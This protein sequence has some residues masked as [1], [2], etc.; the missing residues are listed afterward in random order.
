MKLFDNPF[1]I[2]GAS[3]R[4]DRRRIMELYDERSFNLDSDI[5]SSAKQILT[6][7]RKRLAAEVAWLPGLRPNYAS[8]VLSILRNTPYEVLEMN[9]IPSLAYANIL[10][11]C[12]AELSDEVC[13][14]QIEMVKNL[15]ITFE[16]IDHLELSKFIN[17]DRQVAGFPDVLDQRS[18]ELELRERQKYYRDTV[19][20]WL[21]KI[22]TRQLVR[23]VTEIV[24]SMTDSG[25]KH[26]PL[27]I[28][29]IVDIY[30]VEAQEFFNKEE[31]NITNLVGK[32]RQSVVDDKPE[33]ENLRLLKQLI[34]VVRNWDT[35]AQPIQVSTRSRGVKH[36]NSHGVAVKLRSLAIFLFNEHGKIDYA[37]Q[38][39]ALLKEAFAEVDEVAEIS[40]EDSALLDRIANESRNEVSD[41][42]RT[43]AWQSEITYEAKIGFILKNKFR[44]SLDGIEWLGN[45][46]SLESVTRVRWGGTKSSV[47]GIPTGTQYSIAFGGDRYLQIINL[48]KS[49]IYENIIDRIWKAVGE[50]LIYDL[51]NSLKS[52]NEH[53]FGNAIICDD[54][55][56]LMWKRYFRKTQ[57]V[58][59][60]WNDTYFYSD[61]G[62]LIILSNDRKMLST[63]SF[64]ED[65]NTHILNTIL[66]MQK[67]Y[68]VRKMSDIL[69]VS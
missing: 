38:L 25:R 28:D 43:S 22:E 23:H 20:S 54:G 6:N 46:Y 66:H 2:I 16:T 8:K 64:Q 27:L 33:T 18:I 7:P 69:K 37:Q 21:N 60:T 9:S 11:T 52:G 40:A 12:L 59:C 15:A 29:E 57:I 3:S 4:D 19:K 61:D 50:R 5:C 63:I 24:E 1:Y 32:I 35:V 67:K 58:H 26:A 65:D 41:K 62:K 51:L 10:A 55:V 44:I 47:N 53:Q 39:T 68:G 42:T 14:L 17:Q 48:K 34:S 45:L 31:E 49:N 56:K 36:D 13:D 30:E